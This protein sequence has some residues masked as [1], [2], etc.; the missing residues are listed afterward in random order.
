VITVPRL[1]PLAA[2][3]IFGFCDDLFSVVQH[4]RERAAGLPIARMVNAFDG[5][6]LEGVEPK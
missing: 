5:N 4:E 6:L 1:A 2:G 3:F